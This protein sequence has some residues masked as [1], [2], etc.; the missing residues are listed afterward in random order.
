MQKHI[1]DKRLRG[2]TK[3][4]I[5]E[6]FTLLNSEKTKVIKGDGIKSLFSLCG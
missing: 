6:Q 1:N 4:Q 3:K 5:I 2:F